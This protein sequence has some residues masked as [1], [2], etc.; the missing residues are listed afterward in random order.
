MYTPDAIVLHNHNRGLKDFAKQAYRYR[1]W[2]REA[3]LWDWQAVPTLAVLLL[4]LSLIF[5]WWI[6]SGAVALY[7]IAIITIGV[8]VAVQEKKRIDL[9]SIPVA[10]I[11]QHVSHII[12]FWKETIRAR[13]KR[14][15]WE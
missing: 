15:P 9:V 11:V 12:G 4:L 13:E 8:E 2:S 7:A 6:C 14:T 5:S 1:G 3:R 10:Y